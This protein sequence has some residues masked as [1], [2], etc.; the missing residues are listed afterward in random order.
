M[1]NNRDNRGTHPHSQD[2][3]IKRWEGHEKK[4]RR[5]YTILEETAQWLAEKDNAS[6]YIDELIARD[7][8][9][10]LPATN[11]Q[12]PSSEIKLLREE[13]DKLTAM[14]QQFGEESQQQSEKITKAKEILQSALPLPA[15]K[16][17]AIKDMIKKAL[18]LF[19]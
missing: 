19:P 9:G 11:S 12:V 14:I 15:N 6:A 16:G 13:L 1:S 10:E 18:K 5:N 8:N 3:L 4:I 2:N 7:R 17:G